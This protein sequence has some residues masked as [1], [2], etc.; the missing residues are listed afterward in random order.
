MKVRVIK[1]PTEQFKDGG[2]W[3][4]NAVNP[5][6][7]GYCTPMSKS[8]CTPRRK[9]LAR[10]F[11]K[12]HGF[13][14]DGGPTGTIAEQFSNFSNQAM[15]NA[16]TIPA[17][18]IPYFEEMSNKQGKIVLT[19]KG[20]NRTYY[21]RK[22]PNG[23]W[24]INSFEVLTAKNPKGNAV[25]NLT[26]DQLETRP[27]KRVTPIGAFP[28][29]YNPDIYGM[30]GYNMNGSGNVA[31]H[32][33]YKAADDPNRAALYANGNNEDNYRS[34]G[35]VNCQKP[36]IEHMIEFLGK[37]PKI[38]AYIINSNLSPEENKEWFVKNSNFFNK[39][40]NE[41][42]TPVANTP[43]KQ[44]VKAKNTGVAPVT[45][46]PAIVPAKEN[47]PALIHHNIPAKIVSTNNNH[48]LAQGGSEN[49]YG[50]QQSINDIIRAREGKN[51]KN[52]ISEDGAW[53]SETQKAYEKYMHPEP[54]ANVNIQN[55]NIDSIPI[56]N[57]P[58]R[59][60]SQNQYQNGGFSGPMDPQLLEAYSTITSQLKNGAD[61]DSIVGE[62]VSQGMNYDDAQHLVN[63]MQF[64]KAQ[65]GGAAQPGMNAGMFAGQ[66]QQPFIIK[67]PLMKEGGQ[68]FVTSQQGYT[69]KSHNYFGTSN[70][71][72]RDSYV[73]N[74]QVTTSVKP[75]P[76]EDA[77]I[78]AEKGEY[79][80]SKG[81]L[82]KILGKKH[83]EGGTP[84]AAKGGEFI[85]SAHKDMSLDPNLQKEA[86]LKVHSSKSLA[87]HTPAKV[88]ERNIDAKEYNRLKSIL[89]NPKSDPITK[90][91]AQFMLDKMDSKLQTISK[92]QEAK[93]QP[94][95]VEV[96]D[97]Y[98]EQGDIQGD[99]NEQK[100]YAYGGNALPRYVDAGTVNGT[101]IGVDTP[102]TNPV[103][104]AATTNSSFF[105]TYQEQVKSNLSELEKQK[106]KI[107]RPV[108]Y[109]ENMPAMQM[110]TATGVYGT[111]DW[112]DAPHKA[113]FT[114]RFPDFMKENPD[115]NP[116]KI[117][118]TAKFQTYYNQYNP[119]Y[120]K[121]DKGSGNPYG[122]DDK[123]GQHTWSAPAFAKPTGP[124]P[125]PPPLKDCPAGQTR[126]P[127][128]G[129]CEDPD[130]P[131]PPP[132]TP[133]PGIQDPYDKIRGMQG[134]QYLNNLYSNKRYF[135]YAAPINQPLTEFQKMSRQPVENQGAAA[136]YSQ[137]QLASKFGD[138]T[139]SQVAAA[140]Q[141]N[142]IYNNLYR[143]EE[144]NTQGENQNY[145]NNL[146][147]NSAAVNSFNKDLKQTADLNNNV[148]DK[149]NYANAAYTNQ[150]S[151][152]RQKDMLNKYY[153]DVDLQT[154]MLPY[155]DENYQMPININNKSLNTNWRGWNTN[156][157]NSMT[158]R[159]N[160]FDTR[161][162]QYGKIRQALGR[163]PT[164]K[165]IQYF[166]SNN[167]K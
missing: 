82:Y 119:G 64:P 123:F 125:P 96:E 11:K 97:Q 166:S 16:Q 32:V 154:S 136:R 86:G 108:G 80:L 40:I 90:K 38:S 63:Q 31:Y 121:G 20:T 129:L 110:P 77:T 60:I 102:A 117:G 165:E 30:P 152:A 167:N 132:G 87:E 126:N 104:P 5:A 73:D 85:F 70:A 36:S 155:I 91:T 39:V 127:V 28:L 88:L 42:P 145:N 118:Q 116:T 61:P 84:L 53:G 18:L 98:L 21:G 1:T 3:I 162:S 8:T 160:E 47:I 2:K 24:D 147:R 25:N 107:N 158:N 159:Q 49:V 103:T 93:K 149:W 23:T 34:F 120:F 83:S 89:E 105:P 94:S 156:A 17:N 44:I 161:I 56:V 153:A 99:I 130:T 128:T 67:K 143:V 144:Y 46:H 124:P 151:T 48:H 7:K 122:V 79:I 27:E 76:E 66:S 131:P 78:E 71:P 33:T 41:T 13:Y 157:V 26:V 137:N 51:S 100:Q 43:T 150:Y 4:Q 114:S 164:E 10:T 68:T 55:R 69:A 106:Y 12:H 52:L 113:D 15:D 59:Q 139:A 140:G 57:I 29:S 72:A 75:V 74:D 35:C 134:A 163:E 58:T 92:L 146:L 109:Q 101:N 19:D 9:A 95:Q 141:Q 14:E 50:Y 111:Q 133:P 115:Y 112:W 45:N 37:D 54:K 6:H 142:D 148:N 81:G 22:R 135:T 65:M 138:R 62:F